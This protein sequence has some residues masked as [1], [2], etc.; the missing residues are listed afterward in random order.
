MMG[1]SRPV[2]RLT[3]IWVASLIVVLVLGFL[4]GNQRSSRT[5]VTPFV[6]LRVIYH[7]NETQTGGFLVNGNNAGT[8]EMHTGS[9]TYVFKN[10]WPFP[11]K[12]V[13][14]PIGYAFGGSVPRTPQVNDVK[15]MP[16]F[17]KEPQII[18][19]EPLTEK[20]FESPYTITGGSGSFA[21]HFVFG[22]AHEEAEDGV[23]V[24]EVTST[25]EVHPAR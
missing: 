9:A 17:C 16:Q 25:S 22:P 10:P 4:I 23:F 21:E 18:R 11:L 5:S 12:L 8:T 13:F 20:R 15:L 14:P 6:T 2:R 3:R 19:L 1:D 24:G 7:D